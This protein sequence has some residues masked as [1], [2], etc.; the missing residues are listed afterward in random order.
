MYPG[1]LKAVLVAA[2]P[3]LVDEEIPKNDVPGGL[4]ISVLPAVVGIDAVSGGITHFEI[5]NDQIMH[6]GQMQPLGTI[7]ED[8]FGLAWRTADPD[9]GVGLAG[10]IISVDS[11]GVGSRVNPDGSAGDGLRIPRP[12]VW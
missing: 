5:V 4:G 12:M 11:T 7:F 6:P 2:A 1:K 9:G 3:H 8:R 10:Q